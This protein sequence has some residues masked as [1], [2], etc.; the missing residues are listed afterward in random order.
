MLIAILRTP[1]RGKIIS[2][3]KTKGNWLTQFHVEKVI[4]MAVVVAADT[5]TTLF[6]HSMNRR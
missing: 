2:G 4:K 1:P 5:Q 6:I 3:E